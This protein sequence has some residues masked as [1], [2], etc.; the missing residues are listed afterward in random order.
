M[1]IRDRGNS[2]G[3][4]ACCLDN[5]SAMSFD[6]PGMCLSCAKGYGPSA[7]SS[8]NAWAIV[9]SATDGVECCWSTA[10]AP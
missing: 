8:A 9:L 10:S 2:L 3:T 4:G 5:A 1:C 6:T 7:S